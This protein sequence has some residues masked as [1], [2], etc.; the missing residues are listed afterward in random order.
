MSPTLQKRTILSLSIAT[1]MLAVSHS[2][3]AIKT[4]ASEAISGGDSRIDAVLGARVGDTPSNNHFTVR[5]TINEPQGDPKRF[6]FIAGASVSSSEKEVTGNTIQFNL[7]ESGD[8]IQ[9]PHTHLEFY[10]GYVKPLQSG[11]PVSDDDLVTLQNNTIT[12]NRL[13]MDSSMS[14]PSSK[15][16]GAG[17]YFPDDTSKNPDEALRDY[18][19]RAVG[20]EV[21]VQDSTLTKNIV[22]LGGGGR[23]ATGNKVTLY[24]TSIKEF[25]GALLGGQGLL[26]ENNELSITQSIYATHSEKPAPLE[27]VGGGYGVLLAQGNKVT[28]AG[29]TSRSHVVGAFSGGISRVNASGNRLVAGGEGLTL[30]GELYGGLLMP[31]GGYDELA[32]EENT[33]TVT[34]HNA[35]SGEK[36]LQIAGARA[37]FRDYAASDGG[38]GLN[39]SMKGNRVSVTGGSAQALQVGNVYGN[40]VA[41][42]AGTVPIEITATGTAITMENVQAENVYALSLSGESSTIPTVVADAAISLRNAVVTGSIGVISGK[43]SGTTSSVLTASGVNQIGSL[44]SDVRNLE[45]NV[46]AV[47]LTAP[48]I[49]FTS[50]EPMTYRGLKVKVGISELPRLL[51]MSRTSDAP[52]PQDYLLFGSSGSETTLQ[53]TIEFS[54]T[55]Q[56]AL[57]RLS[58]TIPDGSALTVSELN[59]GLPP[60]P[61][62]PTPD[63]PTANDNAK[64]LSE[65]LLGSVALI[66]QG[67]EFIAD[68]GLAAMTAAAAPDAVTAFGA[69]TGGRVRY[70]TGS[71]VNVKGGSTALG[72][73]TKFGDT[74]LAGFIEFGRAD[75]KAHVHDTTSDGEHQSYGVGL[76][77]RHAVNEH[78]Y[79][80]VSLRGGR[81]ETKFDGFYAS[82]GEKAHYD[83]K[84]YYASAHLGGGLLLRVTSSI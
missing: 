5:D 15:L 51:S 50:T 53:G 75:S 29:G 32:A 84:G 6:R 4:E 28:I 30:G 40:L 16:I 35:A 21:W 11:T 43:A 42:K 54:G 70:E 34:Q 8:L 19:A 56:T 47:N 17:A 57:Q 14:H 64:T 49:L 37:W 46:S 66:A 44:G 45:L 74:T 63:A 24:N 13:K 10:G 79:V 18:G 31:S 62:D 71:H 58:V 1:A 76:A 38:T 72:A 69:M 23:Q 55:F 22:I 2:A 65:S 67:S 61:D 20:N 73:A 60:V 81:S 33:V 77:A 39:L 83:A 9:S 7:P 59:T 48:V 78:F 12:A 82:T 80:D 68:E 52:D 36:K 27:A 41:L 25:G 26:A 3:L